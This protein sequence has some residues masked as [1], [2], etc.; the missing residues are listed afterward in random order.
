MAKKAVKSFTINALADALGHDRR[1]LKRWLRGVP[2][3]DADGDGNPRWTLEA[4]QAAI[5][6][7]LDKHKAVNSAKERLLHLQAEKL[8]AQLGI[9]R[10]EFV[11]ASDVVKWGA[12]LGASIRKVISQLHLLA[13]TLAGL[14][15]SVIES[16]LKGVE[17]EILQQL[18]LLEEQVQEANQETSDWM[19]NFIENTNKG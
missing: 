14:E 12:D 1:S 9:L 16:R 4:V 3:L 18:H 15:I 13:P 19:S 6:K 7:H 17:D 11:R 2:P 10:K 8:E 5:R